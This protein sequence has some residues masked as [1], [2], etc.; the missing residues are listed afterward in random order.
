MAIVRRVE[1]AT[2]VIYTSLFARR[3]QQQV[4]KSTEHTTTKT[5]KQK[6]EKILRSNR[7]G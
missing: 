3:Q 7:A 5:N 4:K 2:G 1:F 6:R